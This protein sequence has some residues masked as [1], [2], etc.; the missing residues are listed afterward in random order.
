MDLAI[1][2]LRVILTLYL[3][4]MLWVSTKH[5]KPRIGSNKAYLTYLK[6][7]KL[8]NKKRLKEHYY[9]SILKTFIVQISLILLVAFCVAKQWFYFLSLF[10]TICTF[11]EV[12]LLLKDYELKDDLTWKDKIYLGAD[13]FITLVS[14]VFNWISLIALILTV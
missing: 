6:T 8:R 13:R 10:I 11:L 9:L 2:I 7:L 1:L 5:L 4:L 12:A 3:I 14:Y